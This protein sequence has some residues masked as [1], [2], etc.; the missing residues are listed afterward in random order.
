MFAAL[1]VFKSRSFFRFGTR[2]CA[3]VSCIF[4]R[5]PV[6]R[7]KREKDGNPLTLKK[8][9][10]RYKLDMRPFRSFES[11][12][13]TMRGSLPSFPSRVSD[14]VVASRGLTFG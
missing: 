8:K 5:L 11:S 10:V 4:V 3:D 1:K 14:E 9:N 7:K 12:R 13:M 6:M 2:R